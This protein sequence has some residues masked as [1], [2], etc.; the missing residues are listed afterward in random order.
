MPAVT[1]SAIR[2]GS[3]TSVRIGVIGDVALDYVVQ[4][5]LGQSRDEKTIPI[6]TERLLG[7]TGANSAAAMQSL[8]SQVSLH[9]AVGN[10]PDGKWIMGALQQKDI[11]TSAMRVKSGRSAFVTILLRGGEREVIVDIGVGLDLAPIPIEQ[12]AG[13]DLVYVSYSP[14]AVMELV[15]G[16][17]GERVVAGFEAWMVEDRRF[18]DALDGCRL[19]VTNEIG[20]D[21]L[22]HQGR[23]PNA[24]AIQTLGAEGC[25][26]HVAPNESIKFPPLRVAAVD[27]TGAGDCFAGTLCHY[28][29]HGYA[30]PDAIRRATVAAALSTTVIGSQGWSPAGPEIE[31]TLAEGVAGE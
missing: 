30:L 15:A 10:D 4:L 5:P 6:R 11:D 12:L 7:G 13:N 25:V 20:W 31:R 2:S 24:P 8:G 1:R 22:L 19:L 21:E 17:L 3:G 27:P 29:A 9:G 16:G 26:L 23:R 14:A 18:R 28:L